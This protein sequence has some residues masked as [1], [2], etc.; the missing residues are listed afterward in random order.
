MYQMN[1]INSRFRQVRESLGLTQEDFAKR[2]NRTRSEIKN[3]E[4]GK[5]SPKPEVIQAVCDRYGINQNWL[6]TGEGEM[7]VSH[8]AGDGVGKIVAEAL[9]GAPEDARAYVSHL[10]DGLTGPEILLLAE[11]LRSFLSRRDQER[12][13]RDKQ[14]TNSPQE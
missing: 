2:A 9:K 8:T 10:L 4:Y 5:T 3:I 13:T 12:Q 14:E 11:V 6:K 7:M 1:T